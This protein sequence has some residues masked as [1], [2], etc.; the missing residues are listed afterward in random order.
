MV[1]V[2]PV[3]AIGTGGKIPDLVG[4]DVYRARSPVKPGMTEPGMTFLFIAG[5][6]AGGAAALGFRAEELVVEA[7]GKHSDE[8]N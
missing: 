8:E 1:D 4:D 2:G 5:A 7:K 3:E 6:A